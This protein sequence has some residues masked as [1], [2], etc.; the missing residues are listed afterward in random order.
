MTNVI[1]TRKG[2]GRIS[3][4]GIAGYSK[5]GFKVI[6]SDGEMPDNVDNLVRWGCTSKLAAKKTINKAAGISNN[7]NK[8]HARKL[9]QEIGVPTPKLY[10]DEIEFPCIVRKQHHAQ[11]K[12]FY[13]C[14]NTEQ[15][16][17]ALKKLEGQA[18]Y[19]SEFIDKEREFGVFF[20]NKRIW[21]VVEKLPREEYK[22]QKHI[23]WN[24][25]HDTHYY[26]YINWSEWPLEPLTDVIKAAEKIGLDFG[27][28][29]VI[30][31][32]GKYFIL[33]VNSAHTLKSEYAKETFAK[34]LD[35]Y[36]DNGPV[37]KDLIDNPKSFKS[38][39][40]PAL[41]LNKQGYNL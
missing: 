40:H 3:A 37:Q 30:E 21:Q 7:G 35:Y 34:V 11:G 28:A 39:I 26:E 5:N 33:E 27:R 14:E 12:H 15:L 16:A 8:L 22:D 20:F 32:D 18:I 38:I 23:I 25:S 31:K 9:M 24:A 13:Y 2:L 10:T 17:D 29:D 19:I 36:V 4:A 6:R 1:L 41:R